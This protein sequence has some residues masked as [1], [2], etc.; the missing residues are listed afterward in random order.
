LDSGYL[1]VFADEIS[2]S[3]ILAS[4]AQ[5]FTLFED[6]LEKGH[7]EGL[8]WMANFLENHPGFHKNRRL[9][10]TA[11]FFGDRLKRYV[12][13]TAADQSERVQQAVHRIAAVLGG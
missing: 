7:I 13:T 5:T 3:E 2:Y 4:N 9:K 8:E 10:D 6:L 11:R 12:E 1:P